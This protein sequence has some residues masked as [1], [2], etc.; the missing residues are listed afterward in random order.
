VNEREFQAAVIELAHRLGWRVAHFPTI[1]NADGRW[2]TPKQGDSKGFPD[3]VLVRDRVIF[4]EL[5]RG[6]GPVRQEKLDWLSALANAGAEWYVWRPHQ[7]GDIEEAL[8]SR[9]RAAA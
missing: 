8:K 4:A 3:L 9:V 5:K 1:Q 6:R 2:M 7:W